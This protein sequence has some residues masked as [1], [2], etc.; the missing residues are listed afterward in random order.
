MDSN[1]CYL[2]SYKGGVSHNG[3]PWQ[4]WFS[5]Y[6]CLC[7]ELL[8][9]LFRYIMLMYLEQVHEWLKILFLNFYLDLEDITVFLFVIQFLIVDAVLCATVTTV[10]FS[11]F[12][13]FDSM[14]IDCSTRAKVWRDW[15]T[16]ILNSVQKSGQDK[17]QS[18]SS[19]LA[20]IVISPSQKYST[21]SSPR[22]FW[23]CPAWKR[24]TTENTQPEMKK[25][26]DWLQPIH[27]ARIHQ[28]W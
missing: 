26:K 8:V 15:V 20:E 10:H 27:W 7:F 19:D 14:Q 16:Q 25:H 4:A 2:L 18:S 9:I 12:T 28:N 3:F 1:H 23:G 13:T 24:I 5:K 21:E 6:H 11:D 17:N 22:V